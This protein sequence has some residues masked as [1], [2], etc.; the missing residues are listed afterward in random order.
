MRRAA[1]V[2]KN[3]G[4]IVRAAR[5][6]GASVADLSGVAAGIPDLALGF[7][8]KTYLIEIKDGEKSPSRRVLTP[9]QQTFHREWRGHCAVVESVE[10]LFALLGVR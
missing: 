9:Q 6:V 8:G 4:E 1:R 3:H 7:R 10:Q 2:D 5:S